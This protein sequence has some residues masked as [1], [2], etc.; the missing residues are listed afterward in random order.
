M[1]TN[2]HTTT[3]VSRNTARDRIKVVIAEALSFVGLQYDH[4]IST[5]FLTPGFMI[6]QVMIVKPNNLGIQHVA[7]L[8]VDAFSTDVQLQSIGLIGV[9]YYAIN[10]KIDVQAALAEVP[11]NEVA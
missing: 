3:E 1:S 2:N 11:S 6:F 8:I 5:H 4:L 9:N 10:L 7:N